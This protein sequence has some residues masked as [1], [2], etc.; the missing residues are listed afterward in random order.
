MGR[1]ASLLLFSFLCAAV[2]LPGCRRDLPDDFVPLPGPVSEAAEKSGSPSESGSSGEGTS[3]VGSA[4]ADAASEPLP[5]LH[6]EGRWL[7]DEKGRIVLVRGFNYSHRAKFPPYTSWMKEAHF[8]KMRSLGANAVRLVLQW[9][10]I[11][12]EPWV[13]DE[14][15]L[16]EIAKVVSWCRKRGMYIVLDMHQDL[17]SGELGGDGAPAWATIDDL[18]EPDFALEPWMLNYYTPEVIAS[19]DAFWSSEELK[20]HFTEAFLRVVDRF[21][22]ESA[23]AG[24]ELFNEPFSGSGIPPI[25]EATALRHF[26]LDV[27]PKLQEIDAKHIYFYEPVIMVGA[28]LPS[29]LGKLDLPNCVYAPH[30]YDPLSAWSGMTYDGGKWRIDMAFGLF[31]FQASVEFGVP[32]VL[33][34]FGTDLENGGASEYLRDNYAMIEKHRV[35]GAF[36]WNFNPET[37][38]DG[39]LL[40]KDHTSPIL[41]DLSEHPVTDQIVRPYPRM[42][43]GQLHKFSFDSASKKFT[44]EFTPAPGLVEEP[45]AIVYVPASRHYPEGFMVSSFASLSS[46]SWSYDGSAEVLSLWSPLA[47]GSYTVTITPAE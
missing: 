8:D 10:A 31:D 37:T 22:D 43:S 17:F 14:A 39:G 27:I 24:Y 28:G 38:L 7:K 16:D 46:L 47:G 18:V 20:E 6:P 44:F 12:P 30:Y 34:E 11:E 33:G 42:V 25:F 32:W 2:F 5:W 35:A 21:K 15:Y 36:L 26:Y 45:D 4:P 19:F 29:F 1:R 23:V 9:A 3:A 41:P 13:F 40:E